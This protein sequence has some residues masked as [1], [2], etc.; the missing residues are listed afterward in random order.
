MDTAVQET[1]TIELTNKLF[2]AAL[3]MTSDPDAYTEKTKA[4]VRKLHKAEMA[5][6]SRWAVKLTEADMETLVFLLGGYCLNRPQL[7]TRFHNY[8]WN[9][10]ELYHKVDTQPLSGTAA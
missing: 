10:T 7:K 2:E 3:Y 4:F 5:N 1:E 6:T 8:L 9:T